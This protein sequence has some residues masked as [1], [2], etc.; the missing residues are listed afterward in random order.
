M[1]IM[2][3]S[4]KLKIVFAPGCFDNLDMSQ[5]ELDEFVKM[6]E[7]KVEDGSIFNDSRPLDP[8]DPEDAET[9]EKLIQAQHN[10][11]NRKLQ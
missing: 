10:V 5:E 9:I 6:I 8:D 1:Y 11:D 3:T 7:D 4:K 2:D